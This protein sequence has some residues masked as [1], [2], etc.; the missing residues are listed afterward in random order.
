MIFQYKFPKLFSRCSMLQN[1]RMRN[2]VILL[3]GGP[4]N[5]RQ[6]LEKDLFYLG[7]QF[8]TYFLKD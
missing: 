5:I 7:P 3:N 8:L 2:L 6:N 4:L 1:I